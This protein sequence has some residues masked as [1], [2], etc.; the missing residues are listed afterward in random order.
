MPTHTLDRNS[1]AT[2]S[3]NRRSVLVPIAA[4]ALVFLTPVVPAV[5]AASGGFH[6]EEATISDIQSAILAKQVT[7][8]QIVKL[9]LERIKA[10]NGP[11][12][13]QPYG[14]LGPIT[15]IPHAKGINALSTLNLRPA[16][17]RAWGFDDHH[18]RS[19]T[20]LIDNDPNLPDAL[21]TAAKLD[22]YFA[23]TGKLIG[24]LHG[25]VFAL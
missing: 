18:A 13:N 3:W 17:R 20:D 8:T 9:Y 12:V 25:I 19:M 4:L 7:T 14:I 6:V 11:A 2:R 15:L 24:P 21:E 22:A 10:Y 1:A 5:E 23:K 16:T